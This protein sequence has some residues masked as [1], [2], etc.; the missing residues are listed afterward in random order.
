MKQLV[1]TGCL[2]VVFSCYAFLAAAK[3]KTADSTGDSS[4]LA[5]EKYFLQQ[6]ID[7]LITV[8]LQKE[9]EHTVTDSK[10]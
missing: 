5:T 1:I 3:N 7:S 8:Q 10:K 2:V 9:L 4:Q 6:K